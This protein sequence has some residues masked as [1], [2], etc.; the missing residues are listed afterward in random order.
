MVITL[1]IEMVKQIFVKSFQ[2]LCRLHRVK[3]IFVRCIWK[4]IPTCCFSWIS[5]V[6]N[7]QGWPQARCWRLWCLMSASWPFSSMSKNP[8]TPLA[9]RYSPVS[10]ILFQPNPCALSATGNVRVM[11]RWKN[12]QEA[13]II[14]KKGLLGETQGPEHDLGMGLRR[15][16]LNW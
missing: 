11:R 16:H 5:T 12:F 3:N 14:S 13:A 9:Y 8:F 4:N 2:H 1:L 7:I 6:A 10:L 15:V